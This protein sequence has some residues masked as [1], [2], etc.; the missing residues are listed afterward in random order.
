MAPIEELETA[1]LAARGRPR[2]QA[3][4]PNL[5]RNYAGRPTPLYFSAKHS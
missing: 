3:S 4:W 5:L 1:Y 2:F